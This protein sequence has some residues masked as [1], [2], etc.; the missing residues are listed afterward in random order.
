MWSHDLDV[1]TFSAHEHQGLYIIFQVD[2]KRV[3]RPLMYHTHPFCNPCYGQIFY[4]A[5]MLSSSRILLGALYTFE[6]DG[7]V[8]V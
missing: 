8:G 3:R 2:W 7:T 4:T 1:Y 6:L 5:S